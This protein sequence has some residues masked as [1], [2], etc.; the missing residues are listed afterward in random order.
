MWTLTPGVGISGQ[1]FDLFGVGRV[2]HRVVFLP[3][4]VERLRRERDWFCSQRQYAGVQL[5]VG[6]TVG[7]CAA[8]GT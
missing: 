2:N 1:Q 5:A 4:H 6:T 7:N 3:Q 8:S